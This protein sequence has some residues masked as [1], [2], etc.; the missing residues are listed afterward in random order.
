M[1]VR[2]FS[3]EFRHHARDSANTNHHPANALGWFRPPLSRLP[4]KHGLNFS[5][6]RLS[7][8]LFLFRFSHRLVHLRGC[9]FIDFSR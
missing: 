9:D 8:P 2:V 6:I 1:A 7:L 4:T 3:V 5:Q